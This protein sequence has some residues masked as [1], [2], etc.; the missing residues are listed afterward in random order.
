[1]FPTVNLTGT[2]REIYKKAE[3]SNNPQR[4]MMIFDMFVF[5]PYWDNSKE[6]RKTMYVK[7][8]LNGSVN[9]NKWNYIEKGK[10]IAFGSTPFSIVDYNGKQTFTLSASLN[11]IEILDSFSSSGSNDDFKDFNNNQ[12]SN[13]KNNNYQNNVQQNDEQP[14]NGNQD[15]NQQDNNDDWIGNME[16]SFPEDP[17]GDVENDIDDKKVSMPQ[18][19]DQEYFKEVEN[20]VNDVY[21]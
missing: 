14:Q 2:V 16:S 9:S 20:V 5:K 10:R 18:K 13:Y 15:N 19:N 21:D 3:Q 6:Q 1:M 12:N 17:F 11:N 7:V 8:L 4:M